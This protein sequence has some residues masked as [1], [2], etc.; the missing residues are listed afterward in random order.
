M[1]LRLRLWIACLA[2]A[3]VTAGGIW[4]VA[5]TFLGPGVG[6]N[7]SLA[8]V[9]LLA[10][11]AAGLAAGGLFALWL[12]HHLV[13]QLRALAGAFRSGRVADLRDLP[14]TSGWG[15][16]SEVTHEAQERLIAA[17]QLERTAAELSDVQARERE[18]QAALERWIE[19]ERWEPL[20]LEDGPLS[21]LAGALDRGFQ[22]AEAYR[23][24]NEEVARRL[25]GDFAHAQGDA[26]ES[27]EQAE[28]GFVEATALL[29]TVR[30]LQR[31]SG[32]LQGALA[33]AADGLPAAPSAGAVLE[34]W[35]A[36]AGEAIEAL[37]AA[38]AESVDHLAGG[39]LRV[40]EVA[41][42]VRRIANRATLV[43]LNV[44]L[45]GARERGAPASE[46]LAEDMKRMARDVREATERSDTL[47][48]EIEAEVAAAQARMNDVRARV[49]EMLADLPGLPAEAAP[50][51]ASGDALR[52]MER[53]REMVQ[54]A[55]RKGERLS[56][57]GERASRAAQRLVRRLEEQ[58]RELEGLALRLGADEAGVPEEPRA[59]E[60]AGAGEGP[61]A[62]RSELRLLEDPDAGAGRVAE[63]RP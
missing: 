6:A 22:R 32:E 14:A 40:H 56:A 16:L 25:G 3:A 9:A 47:A 19:T 21:G 1:S 60:A 20:R 15:E 8:V 45:A 10:A 26:R 61:E 59:F 53:V 12:D 24:Q 13:G 49:A 4:W 37:V 51:G 5:G 33:P 42:V 27:A 50:G 28:R 29:T 2:G 30:E 11:A 7:P 57:T 62:A 43:A 34:R 44:A 46:D 23:E 18:L 54:D 58:A 63:E 38:S 52:L 17:R 41:E 35:R 48:R 55:T 39:L 31:L 36:A